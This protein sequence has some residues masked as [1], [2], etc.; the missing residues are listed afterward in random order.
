[1]TL[2]IHDLAAS[3]WPDEAAIDRFL[4]SH[5]FPIVED[6]SVTFVY[7]GEAES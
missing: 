4:A 1:M 7:R 3:G 2:A 5:R 6:S